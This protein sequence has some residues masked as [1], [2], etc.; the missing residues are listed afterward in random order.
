[1]QFVEVKHETVHENKPQLEALAAER[2]LKSIENEVVSRTTDGRRRGILNST[3]TTRPQTSM[4]AKHCGGWSA[5]DH[6]RPLF[7]MGQDRLSDGRETGVGGGEGREYRV[8]PR[9]YWTCRTFFTAA[10]ILCGWGTAF[11]SNDLA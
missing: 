5:R 3:V 2:V 9:V 4:E 11:N 7:P 10:T 8:L 1:M 6:G